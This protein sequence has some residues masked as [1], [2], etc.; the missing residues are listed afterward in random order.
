MKKP[1]PSIAVRQSV[2]THR[3]RKRG[4]ARRHSGDAQPRGRTHTVTAMAS[5]GPLRSVAAL[6]AAFARDDDVVSRALQ[7]IG[8]TIRP[9]FFTRTWSRILALFGYQPH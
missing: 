3:I 2:E 9:D 8:Q 7:D 1:D 5:P 4:C 6:G